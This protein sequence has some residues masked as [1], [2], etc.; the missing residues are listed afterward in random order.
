MNIKV[1]QVTRN[2]KVNVTTQN[3]VVRRQYSNVQVNQVGRRGVKGDA[4]E[5]ATVE[6]GT[7]TTGAPGTPVIVTNSGTDN[8]AIL[9]FT[10]PEGEKGDGSTPEWG[11]ITG[12]LTDQTD[13]QDALDDK[14]DKVSGKGLSTEDYT[15]AEKT[16]L[17]G[18]AT[19]A[20]KNATDAD[21]RDRT[22]H[23]GSQ[24]ISSVT[25]LQ[26]ALNG[27]AA[28]SHTHVQSDI[29][30]LT[31]DLAA[32]L[33]DI[34]GLIEAGTNVTITGSGTSSDPY[35]ISASGGSG[36]G[37]VDSVNGQTGT[38][39][40]DADDID[41]SS[42]TQK[43]AT[44]TQL[45]NADN[46]VQPGDLATVATSGDYNDLTNKPTIPNE[47]TDLDTTVTGTQLNSLK[48]KVDGIES[49]AEV[50]NISDANVTDLTD[51][52]DTTLHY[53]T[54]DRSRANHTGT[55][56]LSTIS[57]VT[58]TA[59]EVNVLDGITSTTTELN[60]T[61]GVTSN[62][63]TQLNS[64]TSN[65][66][67]VTSVGVTVPT[68]LSVSGSPITTSGTAAITYTAGY[69]GYTS[70]E[71]TKLS[72]I[73]TAA[74][75]NSSDATLL[76]RANHT[77][78]QTASTISD[79]STAADARITA[80]T[81]TGS[82]SLVRATSPT[83]VTPTIAS[84]TNATHNHSNAAGGGTIAYS[85]LTGTP[86]LPSGSVVGT[87]DTQTLTNKTLTSPVINSPTGFATGWAKLTVGTTAPSSPT[88]GDLWV[89]SN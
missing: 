86:T 74:T 57:D 85:A 7:V 52:G 19:S 37:A 3:V 40:L 77:G 6:V 29:T 68:G 27:K 62:I 60:Y 76:A 61:D 8:D 53:H 24:P 51:A 26:T 11:G 58:A 42:T 50:N 48:T 69:Q 32:K 30:D 64:K 46:A 28:S 13:L 21:L 15:T 70:A 33:E 78:T 18:I 82:G 65:T 25:G 63:Q 84:F 2:I 80:A 54:S 4:G 47:L 45:S 66:G 12:S 23:T 43:F 16:K 55:Q 22:T 41:D 73:A 71:A 34:D 89:D 9:N 20:T 31:G 59:T 36:G 10:I 49:G 83:I 75:A 87:T 38:V 67:T 44:A 79:F 5:S 81:A 88:T 1:E 56:T 17:T 72:G 39:V 35:E 14:V